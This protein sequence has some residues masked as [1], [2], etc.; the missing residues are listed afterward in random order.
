MPVQHPVISG[1]GGFCPLF[2]L[3]ICFHCSMIMTMP[4]FKKC[5]GKRE[6]QRNAGGEHDVLFV[7]EFKPIVVMSRKEKKKSQSISVLQQ[8]QHKSP[9]ETCVTFKCFACDRDCNLNIPRNVDN[10][11][12]EPICS[13]KLFAF[14][15]SFA[16][17]VLEKWRKLRR[18]P[19]NGFW[20]SAAQRRAFAFAHAHA[21]MA[22]GRVAD[23]QCPH[24][25]SAGK[26]NK[27]NWSQ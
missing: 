2:Q 22:V 21:S 14:K 5:A 6:G 18:L 3:V 20:T 23:G 17:C 25:H 27:H 15:F 12:S 16:Q 13:H 26:E 11:L 24:H 1:T 7:W 10:V 8:Q 19:L 9:S 4:Q